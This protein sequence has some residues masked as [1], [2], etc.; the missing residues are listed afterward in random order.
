MDLCQ[1]FRAD[2]VAQRSKLAVDLVG[3]GLCFCDFMSSLW[4]GGGLRL[5]CKTGTVLHD[6]MIFMTM[7]VSHDGF[8]CIL[9]DGIKPLPCVL[10][11]LCHM[12]LPAG[13]VAFSPFCLDEAQGLLHG[14]F[15]A[16]LLQ[17]GP[18]KIIEVQPFKA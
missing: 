7:K 12:A 3:T 6:L 2:L 15:R 17:D 5:G 14:V 10:I 8:C 1:L 18:S 9:L 11:G 4:I 16:V 13:V